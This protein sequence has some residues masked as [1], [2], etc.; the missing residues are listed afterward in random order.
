MVIE[1]TTALVPPAS[2]TAIGLSTEGNPDNHDG[3]TVSKEMVRTVILALL[4]FFLFLVLL[5]FFQRTS[6][7]KRIKEFLLSR[8]RRADDSG[9]GI[10]RPSMAMAHSRNGSANGSINS[11]SFTSFSKYIPLRRPSIP[12]PALQ[13]DR[14]NQPRRANSSSSSVTM[15]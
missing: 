10:D 14:F 6:M 8:G 9:T 11:R 7:L 15:V 12:L 1:S 3:P 5:Y 13:R 2:A 4:I